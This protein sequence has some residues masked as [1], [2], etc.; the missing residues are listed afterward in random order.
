MTE[1]VSVGLLSLHNPYDRNSF[2]G[3]AYYMMQSL[4]ARPELD[5][6]VLGPHRP[7]AP[8]S[9]LGRVQTKLNP[10]RAF[11]DLSKAEL[12]GLDVILSPVSAALLAK[13]AP[14]LTVPVIKVT[15]ATPAFLREFYGYDVPAQADLDEAAAMGAAQRV[16]Y[17]S[18]YMADRARAEFPGGPA[19]QIHVLPFGINL[20]TLPQDLPAKPDPA[21]QIE[22][23]FIGQDWIRKGGDIALQ[24]LHSL[25][26]RGR[27]ARLTVIGSGPD[28]GSADPD[29]ALLGYLDKNQP[30]D[31]RRFQE[32]LQR[33][34]VFVLP[35]RADCTPMVV[36]E[37]NAYGCP[38]LITD[39]GG[40]GTLMA[41][42]RNG[43]MLAVSAGPDDWAEAICR[44][45]ED[46]ET[47]HALTV[48]S[49][50]HAHD[51]LT[52]QAWADGIVKIIHDLVDP[53]EQ[54]R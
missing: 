47:Y 31:A 10:P 34:H 9:F 39:T 36:A 48:S 17:S 53:A 3:T 2:S 4:A 11:T 35:T 38:V 15:D 20:D 28:G 52:W 14:Q 51:H 50:R 41:P 33:T 23:L 54:S 22:L 29:V 6:R 46:A 32:A 49:F 13:F 12:Q 42:G 44:L 37:A 40:V 7:P 18:H 8:K 30:E 19:D 16:V 21:A 24:T 45:V 26:S 5:L 25:K 27:A 1:P 43:D